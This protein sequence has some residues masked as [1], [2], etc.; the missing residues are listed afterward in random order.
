MLFIANVFDVRS[1]FLLKMSPVELRYILY[2]CIMGPTCLVPGMT[3][4]LL[5]R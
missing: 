2:A 4:I 5:C 1:K 3:V